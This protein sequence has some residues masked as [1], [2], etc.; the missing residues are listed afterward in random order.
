MNL[1]NPQASARLEQAHSTGLAPWVCS[2]AL[3]AFAPLSDAQSGTVVIQI[4]VSAPTCAVAAGQTLVP[5]TPQ[6]QLDP[7]CRVA[8]VVAQT[9]TPVPTDSTSATGKTVVQI[10][11]Q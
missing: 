6:I 10:S 11:Y 5:G 4:R 9:Q 7:R 3:L 2:L 8:S 1:R